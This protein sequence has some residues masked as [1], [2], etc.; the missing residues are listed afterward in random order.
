MRRSDGS[1]AWKNLTRGGGGVGPDWQPVCMIPGTA[2]DD[3]LRGTSGADML[4][5]LRGNDTI[6]GGTGR[7][8]LF[9]EDGNDRFLVRDGDF[10]IV[11]CGPGRDTVLADRQDLVGRDCERVV[12]R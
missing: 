7:D 4:C 10:D 8:R 5:G 6:R 1:G 9:G 2:R 3:R 11:G 12:R